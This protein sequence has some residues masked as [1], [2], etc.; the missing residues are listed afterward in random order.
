MGLSSVLRAVVH[1]FRQTEARTVL[2][3]QSRIT[4]SMVLRRCGS[5]SAQCLVSEEHAV[6]LL[7]DRFLAGFHS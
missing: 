3:Y 1:V 5:L 2:R 4:T 7:I 6:I